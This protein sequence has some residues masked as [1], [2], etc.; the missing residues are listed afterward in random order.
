[1]P[2]ERRHHGDG[3]WARDEL[4]PA[5]GWDRTIQ[6]VGA[7]TCRNGNRLTGP[8][9]LSQASTCT[10]RSEISSTPSA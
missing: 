4:E 9:C 1:M 2:L 3:T 7:V 6:D 5:A 8:L 10:W